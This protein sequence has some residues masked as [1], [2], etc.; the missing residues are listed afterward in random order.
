M[1]TML[2]RNP[3]METTRRRS[4][5]TSGGST[6]LSTACIHQS[7]TLQCCGSGSGRIRNYLQ[8]PDPTSSNFQWLKMHEICWVPPRVVLSILL[9]KKNSQVGFPNLFLKIKIKIFAAFSFKFLL[10]SPFFP[11][12][13]FQSLRQ[14]FNHA[15]TL[16]I[17]H[18]LYQYLTHA[19]YQSIRHSINQSSP[20]GTYSNQSGTTYINQS[21]TIKI[22]QVPTYYI[23]HSGAILINQALHQSLR[24]NSNHSSTMS[25]TQALIT[26]YQSFMHL[27]Q[28]LRHN[29]NHS[30]TI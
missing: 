3:R 12:F 9:Y 27:C 6:S 25:F 30:G 29:I 10:F 14:I 1:P 24:Q 15:V 17:P 7:T 23:N 16:P 5:F 2:T 21:G 8:N 26:V 19:L 4:C 18:A 20:T 13:L 22:R 11:P 28:S